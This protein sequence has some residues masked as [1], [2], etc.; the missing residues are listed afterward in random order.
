MN[1]GLSNSKG[2][3]IFYAPKLK[4]HDSWSVNN[5]HGTDSSLAQTFEVVGLKDLEEIL[6]ILN[7]SKFRILK[8]DIEG[9]EIPV[10]EQLIE[11]EL[12]YDFLAVELDFL[13]L[14][15]FLSII[16]RVKH[17]LMVY[18]LMIKLENKGYFLCKTENFNFFW[19]YKGSE[20]RF[21]GKANV[22]S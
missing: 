3:K 8:M 15:P 5:M 10:L 2:Q 11:S 22:V 14:I 16:K 19:I 9:G 17:L 13:S 20:L 6:P 21:D 1:K 4:E 7:Q 18:K 12:K